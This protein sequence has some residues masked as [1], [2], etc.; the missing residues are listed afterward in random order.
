MFSSRPGVHAARDIDELLAAEW[1]PEDL[2]VA[3]AAFARRA[4]DRSPPDAREQDAL[5]EAIAE[6]TSRREAEMLAQF[7]QQ[8]A[9]ARAEA[10]DEGR[11]DGEIA[12][13]ARLRHA[14]HAAETALAD[15]RA[16]E[17]RWTGAVEENVCA[18]ATA[19]ARQLLARELSTGGEVVADLVRRALT[20]FPID[21]PVRIRVNPQDLATLSSMVGHDGAP[22]AMTGGRDASWLA[23]AQ[24]APGGCVVEGRD[25]IIDG[26]VDLGLERI[27]RRLTYNN[28]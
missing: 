23:D 16:S 17:E 13:A 11:R 7:E 2:F 8:L 28:A 24:I 9:Q 10:Y 1:A 27:Y 19:V 3:E 26:R 12:E 20:E 6:A 4:G 25:R 5:I 22:V 14:L 18:L 15:V 21:Q